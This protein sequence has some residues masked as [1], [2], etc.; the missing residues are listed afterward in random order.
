[1]NLRKDHCTHKV[2]ANPFANLM[3]V[4]PRNMFG[5]LGHFHPMMLVDA[6]ALVV[7]PPS[8]VVG[9]VL[10]CQ[11][12]PPS[13]SFGTWVVLLSNRLHYASTPPI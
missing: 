8:V 10:A 11:T 7:R 9:S 2:A 1:M 4:Q 3:N 5:G 13:L 12:A 6:A